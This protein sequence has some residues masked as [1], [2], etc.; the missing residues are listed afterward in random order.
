MYPHFGH[1]HSEWE[2]KTS[3]NLEIISFI[4][5]YNKK[6][7]K[8]MKWDENETFHLIMMMVK[9]LYKENYLHKNFFFKSSTTTTNI[10]LPPAFSFPSSLSENRNKITQKMYYPW[11]HYAVQIALQ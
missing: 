2:K 10:P 11:I 9:K 3:S 6:N 4:Y 7:P 1:I 8:R 5:I